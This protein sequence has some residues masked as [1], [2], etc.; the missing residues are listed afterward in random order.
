MFFKAYVMNYF[1][2]NVNVSFLLFFSIHT[3]ALTTIINARNTQN[4]M[5][6]FILDTNRSFCVKNKLIFVLIISATC[7]SHISSTFYLL[8]LLSHVLC[9]LWQ[10]KTHKM[11]LIIIKKTDIV[12][13]PPMRFLKYI[14]ST[15]NLINFDNEKS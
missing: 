6:F 2:D 1:F 12:S 15:S 14:I 5:Y 7:I 9:F 10:I 13:S 3:T 11:T 8:L 4:K